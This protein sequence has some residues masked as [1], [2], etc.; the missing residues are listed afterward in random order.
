VAT[1]SEQQ[2]KNREAFYAYLLCDH[3]ASTPTLRVGAV[4]A[5]H[6]TL[7]KLFPKETSTGTGDC[8]PMFPWIEV[9]SQ[10]LV[11]MG[12]NTGDMTCSSAVYA[13]VGN[14]RRAFPGV[15]SK[16]GA[17]CAN[18]NDGH[19]Q[20]PK[21]IRIG[22]QFARS[23][24]VGL[25]SSCDQLPWQNPLNERLDTGLHFSC[26]PA[27][28]VDREI[29]IHNVNIKLPL[30]CVG[31][32]H[33]HSFVVAPEDKTGN[34]ETQWRVQCTV[35]KHNYCFHVVSKPCSSCE[36]VL[37]TRCASTKEVVFNHAEYVDGTPA[38]SPDWKF[39]P[40]ATSISSTGYCVTN[41][42]STGNCRTTACAADST[43][44]Q[45]NAVA[46]IHEFAQKNNLCSSSAI[47]T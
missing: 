11:T 24:D 5:S 16:G 20:W 40:C 1:L 17:K 47:M 34:S 18:N 44:W 46:T 43:T 4:V 31:A 25:V 30:S 36:A 32:G 39:I 22:Q 10:K 37:E 2:L 3:S 29:T 26:T 8:L 35:W 45:T 28:P 42:G 23:N 7:P 19:E 27:D 12:Y 9:D 21:Q 14:R 38:I 6:Y 41:T 33:V 15:G 13:A